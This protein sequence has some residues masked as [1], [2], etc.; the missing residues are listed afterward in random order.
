M[1][2]EFIFTNDRSTKQW[3]EPESTNI[4]NSGM[5]WEM[6]VTRGWGEFRSERADALSQASRGAQLGRLPT[7]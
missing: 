6:M 1:E 3:V 7:M 2:R 4:G 5:L